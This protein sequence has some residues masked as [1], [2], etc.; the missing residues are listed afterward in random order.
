MAGTEKGTGTNADNGIY[1]GSQRNG[2]QEEGYSSS[3]LQDDVPS[4]QALRRLKTAGSISIS[5][6]QF[7]K[8]FLAPQ[9]KVKGELRGTLANPTPLALLGLL[10]SLTPLSFDLMGIRG[11]GGTGAASIGAYFFMGGLL[12]I[13]GSLGE[14]LLGNTFPF[15]VF[16]SFGGFWL[17]FAATLDPN[18]GA[19]SD[20]SPD[21]TKP[22]L[23]A[24]S[25]SF[26]ASFAYF[27]LFMGLLCL[28]YL[29]AALRTNVVFV[30]IFTTLVI[31]FC[32]LAGAFWQLA[33]ANSAQGSQ[34]LVVAGAFAFIACVAGWYIF[35]AQ[36]LACVDF[37][38]SLPVG[39]LSTL[40]KGASDRKAAKAGHPA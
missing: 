29:V 19:T 32:L 40:I 39:D 11:A 24:S 31:A 22:Y 15:V 14:F 7:E 4:D 30:V 37:P 21:P 6:E 13:L 33:L 28:I 17:T 2:M 25:P 23:G 36:M 27:L 12:M 34:L 26:Y 20:Y 8:L 10:L 16:G 9:N 1:H 35:A 38:L 3:Y 18:F 5:P